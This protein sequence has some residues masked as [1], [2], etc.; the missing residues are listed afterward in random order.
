MSDGAGTSVLCSHTVVTCAVVVEMRLSEVVS[1]QKLL[2]TGGEKS[3]L[4]SD[5]V[6]IKER[7]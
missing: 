3:L 5:K 1:E 6:N 7:W 4:I 2:K